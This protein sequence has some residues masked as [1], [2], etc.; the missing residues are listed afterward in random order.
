MRLEQEAWMT[1][2]LVRVHQLCQLELT[3]RAEKPCV[4]K[5][6]HGLG[7]LNLHHVHI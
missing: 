6:L 2:G 5:R 1:V 3:L 4:P 7:V